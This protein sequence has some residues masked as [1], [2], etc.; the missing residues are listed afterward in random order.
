MKKFLIC[1]LISIMCSMMLTA[2]GDSSTYAVVDS[3]KESN[4]TDEG[5]VQ[6]N[7]QTDKK[8]EDNK[9]QNANNEQDNEET[10]KSD[11]SIS[12]AKNLVLQTIDT[13]KYNVLEKVED[14][15][16]ASK[17]YYIVT[18]SNINDNSVVGQVAVDCITG[19]KYSYTDDKKLEDYKKFKLFDPEMDIKFDWEGTFTDGSRVLELLPMDDKSFEYIID[20]ESGVASIDGNSAKDNERNIVF[21][22]EKDG[23]ITL[24]GEITGAF[25][26]N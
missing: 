2:C 3:Q 11:L 20:D 7:Q 25:K 16:I 4:S 9:E 26:R 24:S 12:E 14:V 6:T 15:E 23:S 21:N 22:Y 10:Q 5:N 1:S 19:E 13:S 18:V 17:K 8:D